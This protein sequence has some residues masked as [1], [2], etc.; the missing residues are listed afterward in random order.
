MI[1]TFEIVH[2]TDKDKLLL[3]LRELAEV[4]DISN[5]SYDKWREVGFANELIT[6]GFD[7]ERLIE[8]RPVLEQKPREP[9]VWPRVQQS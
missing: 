4:V 1:I 5:I 3:R 8:E 9:H 2:A 7:A 6:S